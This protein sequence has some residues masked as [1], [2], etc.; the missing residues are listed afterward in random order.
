MALAVIRPI[1]WHG[2]TLQVKADIGTNQYYRYLIGARKRRF[3]GI[4]ILEEISYQSPLM[5]ASHPSQRLL[6]AE[7]ILRIPREQINRDTKFL[8]L[9]SYKTRDKRGQA[10]SEIIRIT[11]APLPS[12]NRPFSLSIVEEKNSMNNIPVKYKPC[13]Y[14]EKEV[15]ETMFLGPLLNALP[16]VLRVAGPIVSNLLGSA[17][18]ASPSAS[19]GTTTANA[20]T[21]NDVLQAILQLLNNLGSQ[22]PATNTTTAAAQSL[23]SSMTVNPATLLQLAPLLEKVASPETISAIGDQPVKLFKAIGDAVL[24]MDQQEMQHLEKLNPGVDDPTIMPILASMSHSNGYSE[25]KIAPAL[26]AALPA[27]MPV[28]EKVLDPQVI[29]A[30]GD[31]PVKLFKAIGDAVLKMDQQE[32]EHLERLNPGVDDPTIVPL[33]ASMSLHPTAKVAIPFTHNNKVVINFVNITKVEL[34]G[35]E[36]LLYTKQQPL[37]FPIEVTSASPAPPQRAIPKVIVQAI[38]QDGDTSKV[39][40]E[41]KFK[42]K[43]VHLGDVL[44][45][46][47]ISPQEAAVLPVNKDIKLELSFIWKSNRTGKNVGTFKIHHFTLVD[48]YVFDRFGESQGTPI[49]LNDLAQHRTFWHK[50]WEGGF[51]QSKHWEVDFDIK[52]IYALDLNEKA[53]SKLETVRK[54]TE[55]N[56]KEGE[57]PRRREMKGK[58]KSGFEWSL[59]ALNQLLPALSQPALN[60]PQLAALQSEVLL[61]FYNQL[62]RTHVKL[63]GNSGDTGTLWTYPEVMLH[64]VYLKRPEQTNELGQV[65]AL[66]NETHNFPRPSLIHFIGTKSM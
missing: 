44:S 60:E 13:H 36:R 49:A 38:F 31:Q 51:S 50:V 56:A 40:L 2:D 8:Q 20:G 34:K 65:T 43:D 12:G 33:L 22:A 11:S 42:F 9:L 25:A 18:G 5:A 3:R 14:R 46:I 27:L 6:M 30:V 55:D 61:P 35:K 23:P 10:L 63:K 53:I 62:A 32:M 24:K 54:I 21:S 45:E 29:A 64:R 48:Q 1:G 26:L 59:S 39:L 28:V 16:N 15:S 4:D 19:G 58:L 47:W 52:Y 37:Y 66:V 57:I 17:G 7:F 41:K